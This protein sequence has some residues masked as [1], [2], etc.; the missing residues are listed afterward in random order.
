MRDAACSPQPLFCRRVLSKLSLGVNAAKC[1]AIAEVP[2]EDPYQSGEY[3]VN[4]VQ[5]F[6]R[7]PEDDG[8]IQ[9]SACCK[10]YAANSME[11]T[12]EPDGESFTRHTIDAQIPMQDLVDSY[13]APFQSCVEVGKVSSLMCSYNSIVSAITF[14]SFPQKLPSRFRCLTWM[15]IVRRTA[16]RLA[17][18]TGSCRRLPAMRGVLTATSRP[19]AER[20]RM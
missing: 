9:A 3:A 20:S 7:A 4:F 11:S 1:I 2:G 16:T 15:V 8:H 13:M 17:R 6:E 10:H 14:S 18:T 5:G 12:K 19:T